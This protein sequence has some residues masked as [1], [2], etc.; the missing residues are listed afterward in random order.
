M[1]KQYY[2]RNGVDL[3]TKVQKNKKYGNFARERKTCSMFQLQIILK[4]QAP[5]SRRERER[6]TKQNKAIAT[7]NRREIL[8]L[9]IDLT[10]SHL[11][12][13]WLHHILSKM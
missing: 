12:N 11:K 4:T 5:Q 1:W 8:H 6:E 13:E 10:K 2:T 9:V 3:H 7:Y